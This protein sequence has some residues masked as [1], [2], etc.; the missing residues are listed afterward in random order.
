MRNTRQVGVRQPRPIVAAASELP[1]LWRMHQADSTA[2]NFAGSNPV[3]KGNPT[4]VTLGSTPTLMAGSFVTVGGVVGMTQLNGSWRC[5][6]VRGNAV[7]LDVDSGAFAAYTSGGTVTPTIL[8]DEFGVVPA[9]PIQGTVTGVFGNPVF[10]LTSHSAGSYSLRVAEGLSAFDLSGHSGMVLLSVDAWKSA[11]PSAKEHIISVGR[12]LPSGAN[13][14]AGTVTLVLS[15]DGQLEFTVRPASASDGAASN[16]LSY[17]GALTNSVRT[18]VALLLDCSN[19][20]APEAHVIRDGVLTRSAAVNMASATGL[21]N[22][23]AGMCI[24]AQIGSTF[25]LSGFLGAS[26]SGARVEN[27]LWWKT[28][29]S[30]TAVLRAAQDWHRTGQLSP[31]MG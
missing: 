7:A 18:K 10:G 24:G 13:T 11:N 30:F 28:S 9:L 23:A 17:S 2:R 22:V 15:T 3:A 19:P 26:G 31:L 25:T 14:A 8:Y 20:T 16:S 6:W 12:I 29:K 21:P 4:V 27:L 5:L 1:I